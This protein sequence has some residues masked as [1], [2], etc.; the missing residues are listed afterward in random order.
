MS[1][2]RNRLVLINLKWL[3]DWDVAFQMASPNDED[4]YKEQELVGVY[5]EDL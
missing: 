3:V 1:Y 2:S 5:F 4:N